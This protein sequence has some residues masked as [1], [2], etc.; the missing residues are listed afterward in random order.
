MSN[1][2]TVPQFDKQI[3]IDST[4]IQERAKLLSHASE[5]PTVATAS[6]FEEASSLLRDI[7]KCSNALESQRKLL[8]KPFREMD[9]QIKKMADEARAPL[10]TVKAKLQSAIGAYSLAERRKAEEESAAREKAERER[11]EKELAEHAQAVAAGLEE[12]DAEF[13]PSE[14]VA[15]AQ[16]IAAPPKSSSVAITETLEWEVVDADKVDP[17][18][19][20]VDSVKVNAWKKLN[21]DRLWAALRDNPPRQLCAGIKFRIETKVKSR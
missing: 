7:T 14:P 18:L 12:A 10:E 17:S 2:L 11:I 4:W 5:L 13:K 16:P 6:Q 9:E 3:A 20:V 8:A 21:S 19:M 15:V 1:S